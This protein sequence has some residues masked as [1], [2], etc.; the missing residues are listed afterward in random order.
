MKIFVSLVFLIFLM[1]CTQK[2]IK[3]KW[4]S[5]VDGGQV[6][7]YI[8][9]LNVNDDQKIFKTN[10]TEITI[11]AYKDRTYVASVVA[12]GPS[13]IAGPISVKSDTLIIH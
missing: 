7:H 1:G 10:G 9:F 12:I 4:D 11:K 8:L 2:H 6:D 3:V 13:G 5:P